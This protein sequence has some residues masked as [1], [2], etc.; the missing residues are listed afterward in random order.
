MHS[1]NRRNERRLRIIEADARRRGETRLAEMNVAMESVDVQRVEH[2]QVVV[3][4]G[5]RHHVSFRG[6]AQ[7]AAAGHLRPSPFTP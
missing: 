7:S 6:D 5:Q 1:N 4:L 3:V 2:E